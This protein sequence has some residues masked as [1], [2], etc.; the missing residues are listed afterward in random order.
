[1]VRP[2]PRRYERWRMSTDSILPIAS[3]TQIPTTTFRC[4]H[5]S[6]TPARSTPTAG[7]CRTPKS[8]T[9]R[10]RTTGAVAERR[11]SGC[12]ARGPPVRPRVRWRRDLPSGAPSGGKPCGLVFAAHHI[13]HQSCRSEVGRITEEPEYGQALSTAAPIREQA[14]QNDSRCKQGQG[15]GADVHEAPQLVKINPPHL[16]GAALASL[17]S[18]AGRTGRRSLTTTTVKQAKASK[19]TASAQNTWHRLVKPWKET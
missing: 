8:R 17:G 18:S 7:C 2:R 1:M 11:V 14:H 13:E 4:C 9:G 16:A 5:S 19:I 6:G 10:F 3:P 12:L 15:G